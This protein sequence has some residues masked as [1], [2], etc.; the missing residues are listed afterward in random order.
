MKKY[1]IL[2]FLL[3]LIL[4]S[5]NSNYKVEVDLSASQIKELQGKIAED[6]EAIDVAKKNQDEFI[7]QKVISL[8]LA[9]QKLGELGEAIKVY[10]MAVEEDYKTSTLIHNLG[11]LYQEVGDYQSAVEAYQRIITEYGNKDYLHDIALVYIKASD[12][13]NAREY[14]KA[15]TLYSKQSD[16]QIEAS[17]EVL[18]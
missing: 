2:S 14:Y 13:K 11:R 12:A 8:A 1:T 15:W 17:L 10:E 16:S 3:S 6:L 9:Y 7:D 18:N 5:C 4:V